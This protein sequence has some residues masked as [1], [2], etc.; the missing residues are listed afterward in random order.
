MTAEHHGASESAGDPPPAEAQPTTVETAGTSAT[1]PLPG[2]TAATHVVG[3][4]R[5]APPG[6]TASLGGN[7]GFHAVMPQRQHVEAH[8]EGKRLAWLS[9]TAL[10]VV[11][12]DIG[13]SPL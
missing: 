10:G 4:R 1:T 13:T 2:V 8:P 6:S 5:G 3:D 11:Y 7:T 12:G 9:F